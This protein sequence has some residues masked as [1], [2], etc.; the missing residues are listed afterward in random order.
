MPKPQIPNCRQRTDTVLKQA[1]PIAES[2]GGEVWLT[3]TGFAFVDIVPASA[4]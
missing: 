1:T 2:Y 3:V 4:R